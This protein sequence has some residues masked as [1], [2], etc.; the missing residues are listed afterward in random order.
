MMATKSE[1]QTGGSLRQ[2]RRWLEV[3]QQELA[4][5]AGCSRSMVVLVEGG[6]QAS[7]AMFA[8]LARALEDLEQVMPAEVGPGVAA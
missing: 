6:Y 4:D 7:P 3:T 5:H 8:R 1:R 2:R